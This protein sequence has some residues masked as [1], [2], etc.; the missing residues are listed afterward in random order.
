MSKAKKKIMP[1]DYYTKYLNVTLPTGAKKQIKFYGKT[2]KEATKKRN[3]AQAQYDAGILAFNDN[4]TF[5]IWAKEWFETCQMMN[6]GDNQCANIQGILNKYFLPSLGSMRLCDIKL[7]NIRRCMNLMEG[8]SKDYIGKG[9]HTIKAI[10]REAMANELITRDPTINLTRP[11]A[12]EKVDRRSLTEKERKLLI[13]AIP[14]HE[15][16]PFFGIMLA[17]GLRP[18]EA[19]A[20]SWANVDLKEKLINVKHTVEAGKSS[21]KAPKSK[22]GE[23]IIPIPDWYMPIISDITHTNSL[24]VFPNEDGEVISKHA[25]QRSW[26]SFAREIDI[27]AGAKLYRNEVILHA[28]AQDLEPYNLRHTYCTEL[29]EKGVD[30]RTAQYLM[31]HSDIKMTA[32]IYSHV[33]NKLFE[34]ARELINK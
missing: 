5:V 1:N 15:R 27:M 7:A 9:Y 30:I 4:T 18:G 23:R 22:S 34:Q 2:E 16:G 24:L 25:Y 31:V 21:I 17:C 32:N 28:F 29:A 12:A 10:F 13:E 3:M 19:R 8:K 14:R 6:A 26:H 11:K 33:T 20:L